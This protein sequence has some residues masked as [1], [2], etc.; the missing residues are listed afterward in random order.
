MCLK[1]PLFCPHTRITVYLGIKCSIGNSFLLAF[2]KHSSIAF[3]LPVVLQ[4]N[5]N[6]IL[7]PDHLYVCD[8]F[9]CFL[10]AYSAFF[11]HPFVLKLYMVSLMWLNFSLVFWTFRRAPFTLEMCV[12]HFREIF[13][14]QFINFPPLHFCIS[15]SVDL[16]FVC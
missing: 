1:V 7:I 12:L 10:A 14:K 16:L 3:L 4:E 15:L 13:L 5:L 6:L 9:V 8:L 11:Q 2:G